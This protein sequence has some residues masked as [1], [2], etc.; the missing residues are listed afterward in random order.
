MRAYEVTTIHRPDLG[1]DDVATH[2]GEIRTFLEGKGATIIATDMW[3]KRR[4]AYE[5]EHLSEG[6]Y[7]VVTFEAES[8]LIDEVDRMLSLAD[9]VLRHKVV[10]PGA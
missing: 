2:V 8:E 5:I 9:P 1:D 3:G 7:T 10:R 6:Y 4:L